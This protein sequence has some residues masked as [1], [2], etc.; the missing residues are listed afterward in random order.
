MVRRSIRT[1]EFARRM[2]YRKNMVVSRTGLGPENDC[3]DEGQQQ[4]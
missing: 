1:G 4:L 2:S 3:A